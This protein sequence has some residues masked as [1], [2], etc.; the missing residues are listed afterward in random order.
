MTSCPNYSDNDQ[1][2]AVR[3]NI[4]QRSSLT[5]EPDPIVPIGLAEDG[6]PLALEISRSHDLT[7]DV[8]RLASSKS[9]SRPVALELQAPL[10]AIEQTLKKLWIQRGNYRLQLPTGNQLICYVTKKNLIDLVSPS[11]LSL[12]IPTPQMPLSEFAIGR[13][14]EK[15]VSTATGRL[16][17][18]QRSGQDQA[19]ASTAGQNRFLALSAEDGQAFVVGWQGDDEQR[20]VTYQREF[21]AES[22]SMFSDCRYTLFRRDRTIYQAEPPVE[23]SGNVRELASVLRKLFSE[24]SYRPESINYEPNFTISRVSIVRTIV[25]LAN[26]LEGYHRARRV[27]G[28]LKPQNVLLISDGPRLIDDLGLRIGGI[29]PAVSPI[30]GAPE[31][32]TARPVFCS[33][34]IYPIG[35]M[36]VGIIKGQITGEMTNYAIPSSRGVPK[37]S[38]VI[39]DPMI[40]LEPGSEIVPKEG[41]TD[42]FDFIERCLLFDPTMRF[43]SGAECARNLDALNS[44]YPLIGEV[45]FKLEN[46]GSIEQV[47]S[48]DGAISPYRILSDHSYSMDLSE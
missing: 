30:W 15:V 4:L 19:L 26:K 6:V 46:R 7:G 37:S 24:K 27:H 35:V 34:D 31:Q 11:L 20:K 48:F 5:T 17:T 40:Y 25:Q 38:T 2:L 41:L 14:G 43:A 16:A 23:A 32:L 22:L 8:R 18:S 12:L 33:T 10:I 28:D 45:C 9:A 3:K 47:L 39:R 21:A 36:L 1:S 13:G 29:S 44:K 42:W